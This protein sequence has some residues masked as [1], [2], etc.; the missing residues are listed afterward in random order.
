M[1]VHTDGGD[2]F[3]SGD[4]RLHRGGSAGFWEPQH[5][6][7]AEWV[8]G[9][10]AQSISRAEVAAVLGV[11]RSEPRPVELR[12]DSEVTEM[13]LRALLEG[14]PPDPNAANFDFWEQIAEELAMRGEGDVETRRAPSHLTAEEAAARGYTEQDRLRN[15]G[16]DAGATRAC[17]QHP[18]VHAWVRHR[19][20]LKAVMERIHRAMIRILLHR[21][22]GHEACLAAAEAQEGGGAGVPDEEAA[23]RWET[24]REGNGSGMETTHASDAEAAWSDEQEQQMT[25]GN[26]VAWKGLGD[27]LRQYFGSK[28]WPPEEAAAAKGGCTWVELAVDYEVSSGTLLPPPPRLRV[29]RER[30]Y[31]GSLSLAERAQEM[32]AA[33]MRLRDIL[34]GPEKLFPGDCT[35]RSRHL[36]GSA[37]RHRLDLP[38]G[39][40]LGAMRRRSSGGSCPRCSRRT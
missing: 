25:W 35:A 1:A 18:Q 19:V 27:E 6:R 10:P 2:L 14:C 28:K 31:L 37:T 39:R 30:G 32:R 4:A 5:P 7:N 40:R 9:G 22:Q 24:G 21:Q 13:G 33:T 3:P 17:A 29:G 16:A 34:G 15:A 36:G 23:N 12:P 26:R 11:L 20:V 8:L 38:G